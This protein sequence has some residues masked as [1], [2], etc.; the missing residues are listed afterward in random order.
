MYIAQGQET[1]E[2]DLLHL[3]GKQVKTFPILAALSRSIYCIP[4]TS[5]ESER[6]LSKHKCVLTARRA[7]LAPNTLEG[8]VV[9]SSNKASG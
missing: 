5:S 8:L 4:T 3:W 2:F 7:T 6:H 9:V 1:S